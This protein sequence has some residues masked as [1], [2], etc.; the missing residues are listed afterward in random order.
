MERGEVDW[1]A[2]AKTAGEVVKKMIH[3]LPKL[4]QYF[5]ADYTPDDGQS[6]AQELAEGFGQTHG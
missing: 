4:A 6:L 5:G 1:R 3:R 2:E